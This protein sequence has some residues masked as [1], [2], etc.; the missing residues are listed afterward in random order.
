MKE[1]KLE[2]YMHLQCY[3]STKSPY[4]E[5][6]LAVCLISSLPGSALIPSLAL[7]M[8]PHAISI[9]LFP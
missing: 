1:N 8:Q 5:G 9:H 2:E 7:A 4:T 3:V 6:L